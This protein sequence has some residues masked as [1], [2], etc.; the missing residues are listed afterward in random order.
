MKTGTQLISEE[1]ER[2][3]TKEDWRAE[4]DDAHVEAE[5]AAAAVCY[6]ENAIVTNNTTMFDTR[7]MGVPKRW[8]WEKESW[9]PSYTDPIR[10]LVKA[11]ALIAAEID[12]LQREKE[13][14]S[15]SP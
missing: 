14:I 13:R 6:A 9:K 3:I 11:G 4:H 1:R 7:F 5:L 12:R 2:Q 8:P 10:D 15:Q